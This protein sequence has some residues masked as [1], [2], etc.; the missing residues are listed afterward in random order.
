MV[1]VLGIEVAPLLVVELMN[2]RLVPKQESKAASPGPAKHRIRAEAAP[3]DSAGKIVA[4]L[5]QN[6]RRIPKTTI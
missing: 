6:R 4:A 5:E 2:D 3:D 1:A